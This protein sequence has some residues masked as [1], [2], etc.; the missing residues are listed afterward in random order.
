MA[1]KI[2]AVWPH[3]Q[4]GWHALQYLTIV[5]RIPVGRVRR[6]KR[7]QYDFPPHLAAGEDLL[8]RRPFIP[9]KVREGILVQ[10][11]SYRI[12]DDASEL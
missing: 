9:A 7:G 3:H 2:D 10:V 1:I 6:A 8:L 5:R 4:N 11:D 12:G